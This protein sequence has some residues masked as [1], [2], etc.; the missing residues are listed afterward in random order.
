MYSVLALTIEYN[1]GSSLAFIVGLWVV[2][3][4]LFLWCRK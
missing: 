3:L 2:T 4:V 1:I